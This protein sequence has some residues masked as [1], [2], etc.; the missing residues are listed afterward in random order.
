MIVLEPRFLDRVDSTN[1]EVRRIVETSSEPIA[2]CCVVAREQD[3]GIGRDGRRWESPVGGLWMTMAFRTRHDIGV[4]TPLPMLAGLCL[5]E[6]L[7]EQCAIT[8]RIKWPN[9]VLVSDRKLAG[10]LCQSFQH[11]GDQWIVVGIGVNGNYPA[12]RFTEKLRVEPTTL[13]DQTGSEQDITALGA[14]LYRHFSE[15]FEVFEGT[16]ITPFLEGTLARLAWIGSRVT[17]ES[18]EAGT[19]LEGT[20]EGIDERGRLLLRVETKTRAFA[21]GELSKMAADY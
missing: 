1:L 6:V 19:P 5:C 4:Y 3:A 14:C 13:L 17:A 9:D 8:P 16:G 7:E 2:R 15:A 11:R 12:S 10:I 21:S 20:I 18:T